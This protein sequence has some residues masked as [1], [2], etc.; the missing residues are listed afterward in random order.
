MAAETNPHP[1]DPTDS[2]P[3]QDGNLKL[4]QSQDGDLIPGHIFETAQA[5]LAQSFARAIRG[6][7]YTWT[8]SGTWNQLAIGTH[9]ADRFLYVVLPPASP[10][11]EPDGS[12][13]ELIDL[14]DDPCEPDE[15]DECDDDDTADEANGTYV[16]ASADDTGE[17]EE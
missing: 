11:R 12:W 16:E 13:P 6:Q 14:A 7:I 8:A 10:Y 2:L 17:T 4:M 5:E 1:N 15:G 9:L 3:W